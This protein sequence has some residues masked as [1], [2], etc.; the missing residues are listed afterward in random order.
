VHYF[1]GVILALARMAGI[2]RR[3]AHLHTAG[4]NDREDTVW[5]RA[6]IAACRALLNRNATDIVAVGEGT[7]RGAWNDAWSSD[8]RCRIIYNGVRPDRLS[9]LPNQ[10]ADQPTI[11]N[12]GSIQP[13]KNQRRLIGILKRVLDSVPAVRLQLIGKEV[14]DYGHVVRAAAAESGIADRVELIGE[15]DEPLNWIAHAHLMILPSLWEG[16]P[17]ALLEACVTTTPAV[18]SDLPGTCEVARHF[19]NVSVL[20]L[21]DG[22][23]VWAHAVTGALQSNAPTA[24]AISDRFAQSPFAFSRFVDAHIEMWSRSHVVA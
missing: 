1:S 2:R 18:V 5:R 6:Q 17:C 15:V 24:V 8:P 20:S 4:A 22:D 21:Q 11:V 14:G 3:I 10:R 16:L 23:D 19:P 12:V 13:L 7:M 9:A